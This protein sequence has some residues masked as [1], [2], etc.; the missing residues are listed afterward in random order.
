MSR[1]KISGQFTLRSKTVSAAPLGDTPARVPIA[2]APLPAA[3]L[4]PVSLG[5]VGAADRS[6][7]GTI[8]PTDAL[9]AVVLDTI[10][11][12]IEAQRLAYDS[13][14]GQDCSGIFHRVKDSLIARL[15]LLADT[16]RYVFPDFGTARSSRQIADWYYRHGNLLLVTDPLAA[17]HTL[18]PGAVLFFSRPGRRY[19]Q[20]DIE[21]LTDRN[22]GY[23]RK[24]AISHVAI[25]TAVTRDADGLVTEYT[26]LHGRNRKLPASRSSS[27]AVQSRFT[28]GLP[29]FGNWSQ[30]WVAVARVET[31]LNE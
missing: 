19:R 27:R 17:R 18:R 11:R 23:T 14:S 7:F 31:L 6:A 5:L 30:Q 24:G 2:V 16:A 28:K 21:L 8:L 20:V 1:E 29:P 22:G 12:T 15:P 9:F 25:V 3:L 10:A 26:M 4:P 13:G